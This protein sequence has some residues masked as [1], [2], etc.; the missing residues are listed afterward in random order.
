MVLEDVGGQ[1]GI[2]VP[3]VD[4]RYGVE[5]GGREEGVSMVEG[6]SEDE[7]QSRRA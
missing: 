6:D 4:S 1:G 2:V 3:S 5:Q 7:G